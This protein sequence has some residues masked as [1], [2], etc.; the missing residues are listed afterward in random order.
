MRSKSSTLMRSYVNDVAAVH[1][2]CVADE[3]S[4]SL[5]RGGQRG[6]GGSLAF[7]CS[8]VH[9][10]V[11]A[12]QLTLPCDVVPLCSQDAARQPTAKWTDASY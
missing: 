1:N 7:Q 4:L 6:G 11:S 12:Q 2:R 10:F 8:S 5:P 9:V 3:M